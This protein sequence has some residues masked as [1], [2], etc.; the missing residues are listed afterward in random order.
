MKRSKLLEALLVLALAVGFIVL[1]LILAGC[2]DVT[3][4]SGT[5]LEGVESQQHTEVHQG[6]DDVPNIVYTCAGE[7]GW[8][9]TANSANGRGQL[10]RFEAYDTKCGPQ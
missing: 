9:L 7:F 5:P 1:M 2:N 6:H 10:V 8:A 4:D 3:R